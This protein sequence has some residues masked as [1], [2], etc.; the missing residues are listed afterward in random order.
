[1]N[2][3]DAIKVDNFY[4]KMEAEDEFDEGDEWKG[5][6]PQEQVIL[7]PIESFIY[8]PYSL[9][10]ECVFRPTMSMSNLSE[11]IYS[12]EEM[13]CTSIEN[14]NGLDYFINMPI[15]EFIGTLVQ[16]GIIDVCD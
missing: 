7:E 4:N 6:Q 12:N 16:K 9:L 8:L 5:L 1:M 10:R 2:T 13:T 14:Q 3:D 15:D 11:R